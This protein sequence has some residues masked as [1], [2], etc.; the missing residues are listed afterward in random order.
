MPTRPRLRALLAAACLAA[1][2]AAQTPTAPTGDG[3]RPKKSV[4]PATKGSPTPDTKASPG[5]ITPASSPDPTKAYFGRVLGLDGQPAAD[6]RIEARVI[7][8]NGGGLVTDN[9]AGVIAN[10]GGGLVANNSGNFRLAQA[11]DAPISVT[12]K[13]DGTFELTLPAGAKANVEAI[14]KDD[15][16]AIR[17]A[18]TADGGGF[19]MRLAETGT[20]KGKVTTNPNR[21]ITN[22]QGVSVYIPGTSYIAITDAAGNFQIDRVPVGAFRLF[23]ERTGI[24][25]GV[26]DAVEVKSREAATVG[27]FLLEVPPVTITKVDPPFALPGTQVTVT[28]TNFGKSS[29]AQAK[30]RLGGATIEGATIISDTAATFTVPKGSRGGDLVIEVAG[31]PSAPYKYPAVDGFD[32]TGPDGELG[33][34]ATFKSEVTPT[35][36]DYEPIKDV[37][38]PIVWKVASGDAVSVDQAG[39]IT[40][41]KAGDATVEAVFGAYH[42]LIEVTVGANVASAATLGGATAKAASRLSGVARAASGQLFVTSGGR[43]FKLGADGKLEVLAGGVAGEDVLD[44]TGKAARFE[45]IT[46]LALGADGK[47]LVGDTGRIRTV[48]P[49]TGAVVTLAGSKEIGF[50]DPEFPEEGGGD[51][52]DGS[53]TGATLTN[54]RGI[55]PQAGGAALFLD[56]GVLRKLVGT[57]VTTVAGAPALEAIGQASDGTALAVGARKAYRLD[58]TGVATALDPQA[59]PTAWPPLVG[60]DAR[61]VAED[62]AGN[63]YVAYRTGVVKLAAADGTISVLAGATADGQADGPAADARFMEIKALVY[64]AAADALVV[65]EESAVRTIALGAAGRPVATIV[66]GEMGSTVYSAEPIEDDLGGDEDDEDVTDDEAF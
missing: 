16:K 24:G 5:L 26:S 30:V 31:E 23:G 15:V 10:H 6:V 45:G 46:A 3:P 40:G 59:A 7:A 1:G 58:A 12:T 18:V 36:V 19:D 62:A 14:Q 52:Q 20:I 34:G 33:V 66:H 41:V 25:S 28:G 8:N 50:F 57:A 17:G 42:A 47:L 27:A 44:A 65:V 56:Q 38:L 39:V 9:G 61:A 2:C 55:V 43:A 21:A 53:G 13:A 4:A 11:A 63:V 22:L 35:D 48:D 32:V 49:G 37:T 64:D 60:G 54:V 29:G 51:Q